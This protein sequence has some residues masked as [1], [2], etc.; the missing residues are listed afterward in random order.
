MK[1]KIEI[2][3]GE[4]AVRAYEGGVSKKKAVGNHCGMLQTRAFDSEEARNAYIEG[5]NDA[6]G[7]KDLCSTRI[8]ETKK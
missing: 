7:W 1:Y 3:F 6:L 5:L 8:W 2:L 4:S